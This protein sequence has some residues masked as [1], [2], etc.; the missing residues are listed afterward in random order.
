MRMP[1]LIVMAAEL[2]AV[3]NL[4][5]CKRHCRKPIWLVV[6]LLW[7]ACA[8]RNVLLAQNTGLITVLLKL[9]R[10]TFSPA[11]ALKS[12]RGV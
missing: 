12:F 4:L 10:E 11:S 9:S 6:V 5:V 3:K 8:D 2:V 1:D 7:L